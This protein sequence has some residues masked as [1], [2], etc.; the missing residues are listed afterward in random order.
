M[1]IALIIVVYLAVAGMTYSLVADYID[2]DEL[3]PWSGF[4]GL[5]WPISVPMCL[6]MYLARAPQR[7]RQAELERARRVEK[8]HREV[9]RQA[10]LER[11]QLDGP[12]PSMSPAERYV[13][14]Q[15]RADHIRD[16]YHE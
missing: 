6:G 8:F 2:N 5:I 7:R 14:D 15:R 12:P 3:I 4:V 1:I 9:Q 11:T 13:Y 16:P 10:E